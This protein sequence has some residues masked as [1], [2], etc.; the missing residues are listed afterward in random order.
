[1]KVI[2]WAS[3]KWPFLNT[4]WLWGLKPRRYHL[5]WEVTEGVEI[6]CSTQFSAKI[7]RSSD[8]KDRSLWT[9]RRL[10]FRNETQEEFRENVNHYKKMPHFLHHFRENPHPAE[11]RNSVVLS[12]FCENSVFRETPKILQ[13]LVTPILSKKWKILAVDS[14]HVLLL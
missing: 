12:M 11:M 14:C 13:N 2:N 9:M 3:R 10:P 1:M 8:L 5:S 6:R 4:R 7:C